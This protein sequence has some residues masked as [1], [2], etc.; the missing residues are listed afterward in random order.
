MRNLKRTLPVLIVFVF[1][2][3]FFPAATLPA[4]AEGNA[5]E[6]SD[7]LE[8]RAFAADLSINPSHYDGDTIILTD[9]IT[10]V[11]LWTP[12]NAIGLISS[13]AVG[14]RSAG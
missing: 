4:K 2:F 8:L 5:I 12:V 9:D 1:V 13:T 10:L 7:E 11:T 3:S 6:I 14:I